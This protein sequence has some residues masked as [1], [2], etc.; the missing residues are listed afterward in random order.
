MP[1]GT[2][3][4]LSPGHIVLDG[5]QASPRPRKGHH[6]PHFSAHVYCVQTAR[7]IRIPLGVEVGLGPS[8]V[9]LDGAP[10]P[11]TERGTSAALQL[12]DPL[13][14]DMVAYLHCC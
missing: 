2:D 7:L 14:S 6:S 5:D 4:G 12:F 1:L 10:G 3:V 11:P 8:D 13:C 9:V